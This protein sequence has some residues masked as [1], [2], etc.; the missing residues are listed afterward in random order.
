MVTQSH[1]PVP[2]LSADAV[3]PVAL[4]YNDGLPAGADVLL[5]FKILPYFLCFLEQL[6]LPKDCVAQKHLTDSPQAF[7]TLRV[8]SHHGQ[9]HFEKCKFQKNCMSENKDLE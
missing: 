6:F 9:I 7:E 2:S 8:H 1:R 4:R 3:P 5:S